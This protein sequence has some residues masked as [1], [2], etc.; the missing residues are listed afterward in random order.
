MP[1]DDFEV[2][3]VNEDDTYEGDQAFMQEEFDATKLD[4]PEDHDADDE[5]AQTIVTED[6]INEL[7]KKPYAEEADTE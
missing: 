5:L 3:N 7:A 1:L 2:D 4:R 6:S